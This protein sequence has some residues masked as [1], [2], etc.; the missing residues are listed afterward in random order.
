MDVNWF[1]LAQ[2]G[3]QWQA[4]LNTVMFSVTV[5]FLWSGY[6][7]SRNPDIFWPLHKVLYKWFTAMH[8]KGKPVAGR[9][10]IEKAESFYDRIKIT[11]RCAFCSG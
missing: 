7:H 10:I 9:V 3:L 1:H 5:E 2:V 8:L 11:D 6:Q 4:V